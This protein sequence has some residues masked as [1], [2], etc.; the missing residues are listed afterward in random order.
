MVKTKDVKKVKIST[1]CLRARIF[2]TRML[3]I[4]LKILQLIRKLS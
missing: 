2:V 4:S 3:E 1:A